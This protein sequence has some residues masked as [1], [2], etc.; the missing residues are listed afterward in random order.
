[1]QRVGGGL[2]AG[3]STLNEVHIKSPHN[4]GCSLSDAVDVLADALL[5][6]SC[7]VVV[8]MDSNVSSAVSYLNPASEMRHVLDLLVEG[9][10]PPPSAT[11]A[12][13]AVVAPKELLQG[14]YYS[15]TGGRP[16]E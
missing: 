3:D 14:G 2:N 15:E 10:P 8:H 9:P 11:S 12:T 16:P 6:A 1:M 13:S 4:P 7:H 5:L